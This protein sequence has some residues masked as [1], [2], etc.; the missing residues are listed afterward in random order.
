MGGIWSG[1]PEHPVEFLDGFDS[2]FLS[3]IAADSFVPTKAMTLQLLKKR[4]S[5]WRNTL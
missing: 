4:Y 2:F 5:W 1:K 3:A